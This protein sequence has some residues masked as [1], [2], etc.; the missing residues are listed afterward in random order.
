[1][2]GDHEESSFPF[3]LVRTVGNYLHSKNA[4]ILHWRNVKLEKRS[5]KTHSSAGATF[6]DSSDASTSSTVYREPDVRVHPD[7]NKLLVKA[8]K[9][10]RGQQS[11]SEAEVSAGSMDIGVCLAEFCKQ[12]KLSIDDCWMCPKCKDLRAGLQSMSLWRLPDIL[13]F[14]IKRF[15]CSARWRE[16]I[17]TRINFPLTG[18]DLS[19]W[20]EE[21][22][23]ALNADGATSSQSTVYDLIGVVNHLGGMTGGHYVSTC[24]AT[25]CGSD[26]CEELAHSF[27]GHGCNVD[28]ASSEYDDQG[29]AWRLPGRG[30]NKDSL[31]SAHPSKTSAIFSGKAVSD[32]SEPLWLQFDDDLVEPI[33]PKSVVSEMAYVLFYRRRHVTSS[34]V[35]RYSTLE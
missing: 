35:A 13:T 25:A 7:N 32:S 33:P 5:K 21:N 19:P 18:L 30:G 6:S 14:H 31:G 12:Q 26:G 9:I 17:S 1:M 28:P 2:R 23:V 20:C 34:N 8:Q 22:S 11:D 4:I 15:N 27:N 24:K 29:N 10:K 16:K 3:S